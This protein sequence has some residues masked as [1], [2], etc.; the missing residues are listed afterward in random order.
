MK[1]TP[2]EVRRGVPHLGAQEHLGRL[3]VAYVKFFTPD[4][5]WTWYVTYAELAIS[6]VIWSSG[7]CGAM[8]LRLVIT[9]FRELLLSI[10]GRPLSA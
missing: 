10:I 7:S 6:H 5:S 2:E 1:L 8:S 3:A 9:S 4:S